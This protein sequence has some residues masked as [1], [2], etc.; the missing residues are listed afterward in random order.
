MLE[1]VQPDLVSSSDSYSERFAGQIGCWLLDRQTSILLDFMKDYRGAQVLDVGGG[2]AQVASPLTAKGHE[3]T[4][5]ASDIEATVRLK[6]LVHSPPEIL[7][8][9]LTRPSV[10]DRSY[11]VVTAFRMIAHIPNWPDFIAQL[12]RVSDDTVIVDFPI[13]SGLH[14]W[15]PAFFWAKK[16]VEK[17]TRRFQSVTMPEITAVFAKNG[18]RVDCHIGQFALPMTFHRALKSPRISDFLETLLSPM[19]LRFG[20]PV[21]LRA[22]RIHQDARRAE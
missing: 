8:G 2:H 13:A 10:A 21:I 16:L 17:D 7:I 1:F 3:V 4:V 18:F 6:R 12:C 11:E 14:A 20:N 22:R 9:D 15:A 19:T 5:L